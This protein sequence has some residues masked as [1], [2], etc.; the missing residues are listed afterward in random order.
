VTRGPKAGSPAAIRHARRVGGLLIAVAVAATLVVPIVLGGRE[1]LLAALHFSIQGYFGI[2]ALILASW[3]GRT[4]KLQLLLHRLGVRASLLRALGIS[5]ATDFAFV[6]TPGGVGGYAASVYY[7]R[8]AGASTSGAAAVT[9]A[10]QGMDVLFFV[11]AL[12]L[13]ALGLIW[14]D[15]PRS[16]STIALATSALIALAAL[17]AWFSRRRLANWLG[18]ISFGS[19]WP[20]LVRAQHAL[21]EFVKRMHADARLVFSAGPLFLFY[22]FALTVLQQVTRYGI[23]WL[24]LLLLGYPVSFLLIFL[25]QVFVLQAASWTGVPAGAGSAE[26]GLSATLITWVPGPGLATAL[27]LWRL[28]TLHV[29]LVAGAIAIAVLAR[30]HKR[31]NVDAEPAHRQA[32]AAH[33]P[34]P[35]P[36]REASGGIAPPQNR[37]Y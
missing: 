9:A 19:R 31:P 5:L 6:T 32:D 8:R 25:L 11:V 23:L 37:P 17:V 21:T 13:A 36:V 33:A 14:S 4:L 30:R 1:A 16:L 12:P 2:F 34:M 27:L 35:A 24:A 29:G 22:I 28:A 15:V 18:S 20:R 7:L 10:D 26:L 3:A